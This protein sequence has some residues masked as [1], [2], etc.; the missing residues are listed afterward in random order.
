M[1]WARA[2]L[3][4]VPLAGTARSLLAHAEILRDTLTGNLGKCISPTRLSK[5]SGQWTKPPQDWTP[6]PAGGM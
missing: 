3:I 4:S 5:E 1:P 2:F 6:D